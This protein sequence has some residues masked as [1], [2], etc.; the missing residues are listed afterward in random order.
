MTGVCEICRAG[1]AR[2]I[3]RVSGHGA[4]HSMSETT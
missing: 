2:Y 3:L 4:T 1:M